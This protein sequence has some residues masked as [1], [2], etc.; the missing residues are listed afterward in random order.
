NNDYSKQ[1]FYFERDI[2]LLKEPP[3]VWFIFSHTV[4]L[5]TDEEPVFLYFLDR[6]GQR[7]DHFQRQ[8]ASA[9]LYDLTKAKRP[10]AGGPWH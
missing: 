6:R 9:Y 5:G 10:N 2:D 4:W 8:K 7:L 3:R 1:W